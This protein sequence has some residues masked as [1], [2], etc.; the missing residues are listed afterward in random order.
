MMVSIVALHVLGFFILIAF[1][2]PGTT[3]ISASDSG[4][5]P[6][7]LGMRHAFDADHISAIDNTTRKL[8]NERHGVEGTS[9]RSHS[10]TTS[11]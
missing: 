8:L 4:R 5:S 1:V 3:R 6:Y 11:H 2:V 9:R 10:A 7:T